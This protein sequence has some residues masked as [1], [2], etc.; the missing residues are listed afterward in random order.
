MDRLRKRLIVVFCIG[1]FLCGI[2][3]GIAFAEF[4]ALS[5]GGEHVLIEG[6]M[7]TGNYDVA[8]QPEDGLCGIVVGNGQSPMYVQTDKSVPVNTVRF[9]ITYNAE[10]IEP[11][12]FLQ[13]EEGRV[14]F[15]WRWIDAYDD[16]ALMLEAKDIVLQNLK[17]GKIV[18]LYTPDFAEEVTVWVNPESLDDVEL[19]Y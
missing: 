16:V 12:A 7:Q 1:V 6:D 3:A 14:V 15:S 10:L 18:S 4:G 5:Y 19:I 17:D 13:P 8:F 11:Y 2:G 9:R